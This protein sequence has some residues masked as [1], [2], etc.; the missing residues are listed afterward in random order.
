MARVD[1]PE[2]RVKLEDLSLPSVT[3]EA[4]AEEPALD[5]LLLAIRADVEQTGRDLVARAGDLESGDDRGR[6]GRRVAAAPSR[7]GAVVGGR[8]VVGRVDRRARCGEW[9]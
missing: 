4:W 8:W 2:V 5:Q 6:T 3:V 7:P 1:V 9:L